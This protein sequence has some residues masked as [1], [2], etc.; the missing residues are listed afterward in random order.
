MPIHDWTRL[1]RESSI[2]S[3]SGGSVSS[4]TYSTNVYCRGNTTRLAEQQGAGF[5]PNVLT[6]KASE[7]AAA[8]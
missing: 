4:R 7:S 5:E 3:I 8:G 2:I 1:M 6:L